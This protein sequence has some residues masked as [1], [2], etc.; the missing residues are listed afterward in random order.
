MLLEYE[1]RTTVALEEKSG[2][3]N[4]RKGF[5]NVDEPSRCKGNRI[6]DDRGVLVSLELIKL[7]VTHGDENNGADGGERDHRRMVLLSK[8]LHEYCSWAFS[9]NPRP[10]SYNCFDN[11]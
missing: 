3:S 9:I 4:S 7:R 5:E 6:L 10:I 11:L 8:V 1:V 2:R